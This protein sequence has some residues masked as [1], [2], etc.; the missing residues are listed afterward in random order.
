MNT[1]SICGQEFKVHPTYTSACPEKT[2]SQALD[3]LLFAVKNIYEKELDKNSLA[4]K[5]EQQEYGVLGRKEK[6]SRQGEIILTKPFRDFIRQELGLS[7][8]QCRGKD[9]TPAL[10]R[11]AI[12]QGGM[13]L[14][15]FV[16][17]SDGLPQNQTA[18]PV[19]W[20]VISGY[21]EQPGKTLLLVKHGGA[22]HVFDA[23]SLILSAHKTRDLVSAEQGNLTQEDLDEVGSLSG[24]SIVL[25]P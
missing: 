18:S 7:E 5:A 22:N 21:R 3:C 19:A 25:L 24:K 13:I 14:I 12:D 15:P 9:L 20:G 11:E 2:K 4:A 10:A 16:P 17:G 23:Q 6:L 1:T 8:S